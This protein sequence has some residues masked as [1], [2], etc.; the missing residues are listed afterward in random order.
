[1]EE[2]K[3]KQT[4]DK[5]LS[6]L[7]WSEI[8]SACFMKQIKEK[9]KAKA[10]AKGKNNVGYISFR[11]VAFIAMGILLLAGMAIAISQWDVWVK[12]IIPKEMEQGV[13]SSWSVEDKAWYSSW[14]EENG[15]S[16][17]LKGKNVLP[18]SVDI[19]Q[20]AAQILAEEYL[21]KRYPWFEEEGES[22]I[23]SAYFYQP[24]ENT[25]E[26]VWAFTYE[27]VN[28]LNRNGYNNRIGYRLELQSQTGELKN[29]YT[30]TKTDLFKAPSPKEEKLLEQIREIYSDP[31]NIW[32][33]ENWQKAEE[34]REK[35]YSGEGAYVLGLPQEGTVAPS[36]AV[37]G[38]LDILEEARFLKEGQDQQYAIHLSYYT[39][40][41]YD[42]VWKV[43][44]WPLDFN[45]TYQRGF[46]VQLQARTG[47]VVLAQYI[48]TEI[49]PQNAPKPINSKEE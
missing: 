37:R 30:I 4:L 19:G 24:G 28:R 39:N 38:A 16:Y 45:K 18:Q 42:E 25:H 43:E 8:N 12:K 22:Y 11:K 1:M 48:T 21:S 35:Y 34:V 13:Y 47:E 40:S 15:L 31:A 26:R 2:Y 44:L 33:E 5:E 23:K 7:H 20:E 9:G 3:L 41:P 32:N 10:K 49:I 6:F 27:R 46:S 29:I 36:Q 14:K 17:S